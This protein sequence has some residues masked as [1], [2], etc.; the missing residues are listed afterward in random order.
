MGVANAATYIWY[1]IIAPSATPAAIVAKLESI[2][3]QA[4]ATTSFKEYL[5]TVGMQA[6]LLNARAMR[7][8]I[9][10]EY[11]INSLISKDLKMQQ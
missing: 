5:Q 3:Q 1:G 6:T 4:A 2:F 9:D 7:K 11:V 10:E 8:I